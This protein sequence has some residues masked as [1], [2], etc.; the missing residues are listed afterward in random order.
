[1]LHA[2]IEFQ[3]ISSS[4]PEDALLAVLRPGNI[5]QSTGKFKRIEDH[6]SHILMAENDCVKQIVIH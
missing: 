6:P 1:M 4:F 3:R 5:T 2:R